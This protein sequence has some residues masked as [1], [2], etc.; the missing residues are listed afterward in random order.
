MPENAFSGIR[1][2]VAQ[3]A[4]RRHRNL[5]KATDIYLLSLSLLIIDFILSISIVTATELNPPSGIITSAY[6]LAVRRI[7]RASA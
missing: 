1:K 7:L 5:G 4:H 3:I 2:K 6:F